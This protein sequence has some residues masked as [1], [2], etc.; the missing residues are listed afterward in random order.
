[1]LFET[2]GIVMRRLR[3]MFS[4]L[5]VGVFG[6]GLAGC[7]TTPS[8]TVSSS[9]VI[10]DVRTP[11]EYAAGHLENAVNINWEGEFTSVIGE[12]PKDGEYLLY[13]R[14]GNRAGQAKAF[15]DSSGYTNVTNLGSVQ[16]AAS[17]TGLSVVQ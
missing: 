10:I 13:C 6:I 3:M 7:A 12:L 9:T 8:V 2:K 16:D 11:E 4:A 17:A 15:M 1:M 14:S 5:L